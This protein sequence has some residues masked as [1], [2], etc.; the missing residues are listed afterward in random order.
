M[1]RTVS[2]IGLTSHRL[3]HQRVVLKLQQAE[4]CCC[5]EVWLTSRMLVVIGTW[6]LTLSSCQVIIASVKE[7]NV[8]PLCVCLLAG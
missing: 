5:R 2:E 8:S 7:V 4:M 6:M 1:N 3:F